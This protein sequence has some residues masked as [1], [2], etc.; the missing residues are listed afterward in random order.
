MPHD[1][2]ESHVSIGNFNQSLEQNAFAIVEE[3]DTAEQSNTL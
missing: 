1:F 3:S 2:R